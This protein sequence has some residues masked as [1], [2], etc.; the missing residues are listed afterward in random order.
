MKAIVVDDAKSMRILAGNW[1]DWNMP[2]MAVHEL[3]VK[4]RADAR[5]RL[6]PIMMVS[7]ES[8]EVEITRVL[9]AGANAY[10]AKP[11]AREGLR[12]RLRL[13]GFAVTGD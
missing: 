1:V 11:M 8:R 2:V 13:I 5:F 7:T 9:A 10:L 3:L 6:M 4:L 12:E